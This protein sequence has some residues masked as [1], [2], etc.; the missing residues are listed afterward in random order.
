MRFQLQT[1]LGLSKSRYIHNQQLSSQTTRNSTDRAKDSS[2][3]LSLSDRS[4]EVHLVIDEEENIENKERDNGAGRGAG[5][6]IY[7]PVIEF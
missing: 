5:G 7:G 4:L 2:F 3:I 6:T 1:V